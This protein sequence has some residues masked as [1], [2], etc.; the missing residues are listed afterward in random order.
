MKANRETI[1]NF[2]RMFN[3]GV[4]G[5]A[6]LA[7]TMVLPIYANN[8]SVENVAL[9]G[10]N[11]AQ[12]YAYVQFDLSWDNS[13][14][15]AT[16]NNHDAAWV[17]VKYRK[18]GETAWYHAYLS[19]TDVDHSVTT[20][21]SVTPAFRVGTTDAKGMGV[22]IYRDGDD[23]GSIDWDGVKL[24]WMYAQNT[25]K[26]IGDANR[27]N[28]K[29]FA[30]EMVYIPQGDF[31]VGDGSSP[32]RFEGTDDKPVQITTN[33]TTVRMDGTSCSGD[34][35]LQNGIK[36]DGDGGIAD[37]ANYPTGYTAFYCMKYE[38]SQGQYADFLNTLTS[39]QDGNRYSS[40]SY[41]YTISRSQDIDIAG[42]KTKHNWVK[43]L[44]PSLSGHFFLTNKEKRVNLLAK[45]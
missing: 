10:Q 35:T 40:T 18:Q 33:E 3:A 2:G 6:L 27:V 17:F 1:H 22:F 31:Y 24:K 42:E 25:N 7:L 13:W 20:N 21:N 19:T 39:T 14:K 44:V 26:V 8:I 5:V 30:I 45:E 38:I 37:N 9:T 11:A 32:S 23:T 12:D 28:V 43:V 4:F 41:R 29:V 36:V 34:A 16:P 15:T